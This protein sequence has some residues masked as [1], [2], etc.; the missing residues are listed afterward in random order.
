M[1]TAPD[2]EC[3]LRKHCRNTGLTPKARLGDIPMLE[4][5]IAVRKAVRR[6]H[7]RK[8]VPQGKFYC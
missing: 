2:Y 3:A 5:N 7:E 1:P 6:G 8:T 4:L